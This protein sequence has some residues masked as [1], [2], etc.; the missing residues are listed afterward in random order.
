M[1]QHKTNADMQHP[2]KTPARHPW[3]PFRCNASLHLAWI[4][5]IRVIT[6][7][8][9]EGSWRWLRSELFVESETE[10]WR[11]RRRS[12]AVDFLEL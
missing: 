11:N 4:G 9:G 3:N 7:A 2:N 6:V 10:G 12:L 8:I 5:L 1:L